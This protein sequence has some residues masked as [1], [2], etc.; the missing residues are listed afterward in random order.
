MIR[1]KRYTRPRCVAMRHWILIPRA[2]KYYL[3]QILSDSTVVLGVTQWALEAEFNG[4]II[5]IGV[6]QV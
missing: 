2:L 3:Y 1:E 6:I 5:E 4:R